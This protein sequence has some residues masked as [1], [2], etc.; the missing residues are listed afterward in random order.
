MGIENM[1]NEQM[2]EVIKRFRNF[3]LLHSRTTKT[4]LALLFKRHRSFKQSI[5]SSSTSSILKT[6]PRKSLKRSMTLP[7]RKA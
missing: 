2:K 4:K 3:L 5:T 7:I 6:N 1:S